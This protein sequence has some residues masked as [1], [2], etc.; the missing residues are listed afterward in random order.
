MTDITSLAGKLAALVA[1]NEVY[2]DDGARVIS[3]GGNPTPLMAVLQEIDDTVL[4]R[5]LMFAFGDV[6]ISLSVAG[7]RLR[8]VVEIK[9]KVAGGPVLVGK[10]LSSEDEKT[11]KSLGNILQKLSKTI[12]FVTVKSAPPQS[13]GGNTDAGLPASQ[14]ADVW[15]VDL[16]EEPTPPMDRF[17]TACAKK[18]KDRISLVDMAAVEE[19]GD[20][21]AL[22]PL[23]DQQVPAF[24]KAQKALDKG[25]TGPLLVCLD[26][27]IIDDDPVAFALIENAGCLFS[28]ASSDL[29]AI[30]SSWY[31][32]S[33]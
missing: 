11:T 6:V 14:L 7:R 5:T 22:K 10:L 30:L 12:A 9:G 4:E 13:I 15:N 24:L 27:P 20:V 29:P 17:L 18:I 33:G 28:Y 3:R 25:Y 1:E 16:D 31:A 8:G 2:T 23:L 32:T 19:T 26:S 21:D